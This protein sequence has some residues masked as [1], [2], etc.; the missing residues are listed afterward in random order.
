MRSVTR[1]RARSALVSVVALVL[2]AGAAGCDSGDDIQGDEEAPTSDRAPDVPAVATVTTL[3]HIGNRLDAEHRA[4]VKTRVTE[5]VDAFFDGAYLGAFPRSDYSAAFEGF[6]PGAAADAQADL[7]IMTSSA[8]SDQI[9]SATATK[10]RVTVDVLA[11]EGHP[12]GVTAHFFLD[13]D[14]TGDLE[15]SMRVRGDLYLS[16]VKG[17][18][19]VFGYDVDEAEQ[20]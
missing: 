10:R 15:A 9:E 6:T 19:Q 2:F 16:K 18:W 17:E 1:P 11:F 3:Q 13:F 5:A 20:R 14:T 12:R 4:K 8:I 7:D